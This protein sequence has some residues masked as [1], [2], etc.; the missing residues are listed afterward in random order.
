M[1]VK[2]LLEYYKTHTINE[3]KNKFN[4]SNYSLYKI[5]HENNIQKPSYKNISIDINKLKNY[6]LIENN[7]F[8]S[9]CNHFNISRDILKAV[10]KANNI[11]KKDFISAN[12]QKMHAVADSIDKNIFVNYYK[13]HSQ[14]DTCKFFNIR[15][16][17][18][19]YLIKKYSLQKYSKPKQIKNSFEKISSQ[20][21]Y[22]ELFDLYIN[23][24]L[25][26]CEVAE[27]LKISKNNVEKLISKYNIKK[28]ISSK[29][30]LAKQSKLLNSKT[31]GNPINYNKY[32]DEFKK[33]YY[34]KDLSEAFLDV[35]P[36]YKAYQLAERFNCNPINIF[37]WVKRLGLRD[38]IIDERSHY[39]QEICDFIYSIN[40]NLII[41]HN[42]R[43]ILNNKEIDLYL[44]DI[45]L[46]IEFNGTY[47][48]S[49]ELLNNHKY[50][51]NKSIECE[52]LGI[53]LIHIYEYEWLDLRKKEIIKS[54]IRIAL[55]YAS[56]RIYARCCDIRQIS[57]QE[58]KEFN[59]KYH[60]Q[61][62]RNAKISLGLFYN[63]E[64]I[65]LMSFSNTK[66]NRNLNTSDDWEILRSCTLPDTIVIGGV[67]KLFNYFKKSYKPKS[68][69]SYCDFNKFNGQGYLNLGMNF[70]GYTG[71][72]LKYVIDDKVYNRNPAKY[73][74]HK[75]KIDY[76][77]Y[78]AGSKKYCI[79]I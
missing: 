15:Q 30:L 35:K 37:G 3:C 57:N 12:K 21:T 54:I 63:N 76:K 68:I 71:P 16:T 36:R 58:A 44:P 1:D 61:G 48:H 45:N 39:E 60:L 18:L 46:G 10:L 25:R 13:N 9:T 64:L 17:D 72:D 33:M 62:H 42:N 75:N 8:D 47:W 26:I 31:L 41:K 49:D 79:I 56:K 51:L 23:K 50:H 52:K 40:P 19:T 32:S 65:Q 55:G 70:I 4:I 6:F 74:Q 14:I 53:R 67:S 43:K 24:N 69:F 22:E 73:Q 7:S 27:T 11:S 66:Y 78:G 29:Y 2:A 28:D 34:D 59:N 77:I 38:Y 20:I 5:L